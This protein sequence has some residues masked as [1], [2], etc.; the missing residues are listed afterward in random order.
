MPLN[1]Y[2]QWARR[3]LEFPFERREF[4]PGLLTWN[5]NRFKYLSVCSSVCETRK[6]RQ[7]KF[8]EIWTN[9]DPSVNFLTFHRSSLNFR[10]LYLSFALTFFSFFRL[11]SV[12][13]ENIRDLYFRFPSRLPSVI[14]NRCDF[15]GTW[16]ATT[17]R[18]NSSVFKNWTLDERQII[19][20][21]QINCETRHL[22]R[23]VEC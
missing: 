7:L 15:I 12:V 13:N 10:Y 9:G 18:L 20:G 4:V 6:A 21:F 3:K 14:S 16:R 19:K 2:A 23:Y 22:L 5:R 17:H 8:K 1:S 11:K